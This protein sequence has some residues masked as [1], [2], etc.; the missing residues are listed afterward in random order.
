MYGDGR[1]PKRLKLVLAIELAVVF[2][3][4]STELSIIPING[5]I[6]IPPQNSIIHKKTI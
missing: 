2:N 1:K 6:I 4:S 5:G 3:P